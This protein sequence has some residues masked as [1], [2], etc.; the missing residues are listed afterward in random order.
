MQTLD[1]Y[2]AEH[3]I[4][5]ARISVIKV[6]AKGGELEVLEGARDTLAAG[7]PHVVV[8]VIPHRPGERGNEILKYMEGLGYKADAP[9]G[10]LAGEVVY[11]RAREVTQEARRAGAPAASR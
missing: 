7:A 8:K 2:V 5:S 11:T 4:D 3:E 10:D 9:A 6:D 1:S